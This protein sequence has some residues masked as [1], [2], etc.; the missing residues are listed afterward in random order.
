MKQ[1]VV[2]GLL[3]LLLLAGACSQEPAALSSPS[4]PLRVTQSILLASKFRIEA[5]DT[6]LLPA[7]KL[8]ISDAEIALRSGTFSVM[9]KTLTPPSGDKHDYMSLGSYW[10]PDPKK[11]DGLPY[12]RKDGQRNP[13]TRTNKVDRASLGKMADTASALAFAYGLSGEE[14]YAKQAGNIIRVWF[15]YADTRMN[16]NLE[17]GQAIPG[18]VDGRYIGIIDTTQLLAVVDA[19]DILS[20]SE[21]WTTEDQS[22]IVEWFNAYLDWLLTSEHGIKE[23]NTR[24]NHGTWY[25]VQVARFA[26]FV[27]KTEIARRVLEASKT[28]RIEAHIEPDGRQP[29][30]L[31]RT[32]SLSYSV[33]NLKG[34]LILAEMGEDLGIDLSHHESSDGR[35]IRKALEY[36]M[37]YADS[38]NKWP[39][40]QIADLDRIDLL[41]LLRFAV[42]TYGDESYKKL[43]EKLPEERLTDRSLLLYSE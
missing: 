32:K 28:K 2:I 43:I 17:F 36:L 23:G 21:T 3:G 13:E 29:H 22:A 42:K 10:W 16:P 11:A 24:N 9:D 34:M 8:L 19:I 35:S 15:L 7:F 1:T 31:A 41:P 20:T 14:K 30:E 12:I 40:K 33:M 38:E 4:R 26:L 6:L 25:D 5:G 39:H 27:G 37:P 18:R